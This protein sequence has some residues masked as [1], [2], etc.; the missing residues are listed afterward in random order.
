MEY[1]VWGI[2]ND[3]TLLA[4]EELFN[5]VQQTI[6]R[7]IICACGEDRQGVKGS[8]CASAM[9]PGARFPAAEVINASIDQN[10]SVTDGYISD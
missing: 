2:S 9:K 8:R 7:D 5:H 3:R 10:T 6:A 4:E 1:E